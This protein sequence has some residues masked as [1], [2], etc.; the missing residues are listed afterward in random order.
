MPGPLGGAQPSPD[1]PDEEQT[2]QDRRDQKQ[3]RDRLRFA[4]RFRPEIGSRWNEPSSTGWVHRA[5]RRVAR[6]EKSSIRG[7]I[8]ST[9]VAMVNAWIP[10]LAH[11]RW[12]ACE[13]SSAARS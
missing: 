6:F 12:N 9:S 7:T 2:G 11:Q 8:G 10:E 1:E 3:E 13:R 5:P 4:P